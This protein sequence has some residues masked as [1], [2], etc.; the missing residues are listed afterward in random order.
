[1]L[2]RP[3]LLLA[4]LILLRIRVFYALGAQQHYHGGLQIRKSKHNTYIRVTETRLRYLGTENLRGYKPL[5]MITA[6]SYDVM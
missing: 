6:L 4:A 5:Q 3:K 1:M 2:A